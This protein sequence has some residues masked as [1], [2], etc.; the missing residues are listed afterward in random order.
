MNARVSLVIPV[1]NEA[2]TI[3]D[4]LKAVASQ[5]VRPLEVIVVD[6]NS[7]DGTG[8][9]AASFDFV[10]VLYESRQGVVYARDRG[11]DV[12]RGEIIGRIDAD[13]I[14][15]ENWIATLQ[16]QCNKS[17]MDLVTGSVDLYGIAAA[18]VASRI[19]LACRRYLARM[20]G[21][22]VGVQGANMALKRDVWL[23]IRSDVCH[24]KGIHEDFD[25]G[26]HAFKLGY[27]AAF[28]ES[29][30][31]AV[32]HRQTNAGPIRFY[33]YVMTSPRTYLL[34]GLACGRRMYPVAFLVLALYPI[35]VVLTRGYSDELRRFSVMQMLFGLNPTRVN[36]ATYLD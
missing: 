3:H 22:R 23:A 34:H 6:N 16:S 9:I 20:L 18:Q 29:L 30:R 2:D 13:T 26:V 1:Y 25:L 28:V 14:I 17:E 7:T 32:N 36:P 35:I 24:D 12:A 15:D 19:D 5:T 10:T 31:A 4:C 21:S 11:F 27:Q 33:N 8:A